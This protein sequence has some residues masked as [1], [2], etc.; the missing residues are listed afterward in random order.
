MHLVLALVEYVTL[1]QG[2]IAR[3]GERP[4]IYMMS[5]THGIDA[6]DARTGKLLWH[7]EAAQVPIL[8]RGARLLAFTADNLRGSLPVVV[9]ATNGKKQGEL[10][11]A[12]QGFSIGEG[13]GTHGEALGRSTGDRDYVRWAQRSW[14]AGGA[15]FPADRMPPG[16]NQRTDYLV[17]WNARMLTPTHDPI[18]AAITARK[19]TTTELDFGPF[20]AGGV[21]ASITTDAGRDVLHRTRGSDKLPDI[22]L[23][24]KHSI[25]FHV[26]VAADGRHV[27]VAE[28]LQGRIFYRTTVWDIARGD[29][30][31]GFERENIPVAFVVLGNRLLYYWPDAVH[32]I[33]LASGQAVYSRPTRDLR[34][35]GT[36]PPSAAPPR[37]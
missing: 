31:G 9:D 3:T 1:T 34:Y 12:F 26:I 24:A 20:D 10:A 8:V 17:D 6:V 5:Q 13:M 2:V 27:A 14:H 25:Y 32:T 18:D 15:A 21:L 33:D 30:V 7:S 23:V 4:T 37:H 29:K 16:S 22:E 35:H 19:Y 28:Q 11:P 36:Y